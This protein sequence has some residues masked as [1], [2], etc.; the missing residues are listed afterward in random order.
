MTAGAK[1]EMVGLRYSP[2]FDGTRA[3]N[4]DTEPFRA[5]GIPCTHL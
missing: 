3:P 4:L 5:R 2:E 1:Y